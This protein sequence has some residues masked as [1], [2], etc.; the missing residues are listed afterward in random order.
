MAG[1]RIGLL[2]GSFNP[3]HDGHREISLEALR[4]LGL[5]QVWWLVSPQNPLKS[6]KDMA[7]LD[8]RLKQAQILAAH[9]RIHA[10]A[11]ETALGTRYTADTLDALRRL[12]PNTRFVWLMGADNLAGFHRWRRWADIM[13]VVPVAVLDRPLYSISAPMGKTA[14]RF[15]RYRKRE[16]QAKQLATMSAPAWMVLRIPRNPLSATEL[17]TRG[18]GWFDDRVNEAPLPIATPT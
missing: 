14:Q 6:E 11:L 9:P 12:Y 15:R 8:R 2:G 1:K 16:R 13:S 17:R 7:P 5:D 3:A 4:R 10:M 18:A